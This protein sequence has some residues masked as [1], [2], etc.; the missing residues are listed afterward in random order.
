MSAL[1]AACALVVPQA[2]PPTFE[3][4]QLSD[5][6]YGEGA[7]FGDLDRDGASDVVSGPWWYAGPEFAERFPLYAAQGFDPLRY[8]DFFFA[9]TRDLDGDR[10]LDVLAVGFPGQEA[11]WLENPGKPRAAAGWERH[12]VFATVSGES[13][14]YVD[15]TGDATPEL[16]FLHEGKI[17]Y[18]AP[19]ARDPRAP[20]TFTAVTDAVQEG[21][22][23]HGLG[24][25]DVDGDGQPDVLWRG[26]WFRQTAST[27][28]ERRDFDFASG[29]HGGAQML[30]TDLDGD[31]DGDVV[32][33]LNA[34]GVG[35]SWFEQRKPGEFR[36][37]RVM[38]A[39][40]KDSP[41]GFCV[42]EL[43]ALALGDVD[44]DGVDDVVT[45][46]RFWAHGPE[47][48]PGAG[49]PADLLWFRTVRR[50]S[51]GGVVVELV[52]H[53]IDCDSGVGTQVTAGDVDGDG[54]A[55][56][57]VG[58]K[59]GSFVFLNREGGR[60][61]AAP[62]GRTLN[63]GFEDGS[64]ADWRA[65]GD[66][67]LDQP[68]RGDAPVARDREPA[69]I[70][71]DFFVGGYEHR[72]DD[73]TGRLVSA[74]FRINAPYLSFLVGGGN[75]RGTRVEL[76]RVGDAEPFFKT[77]GANSETMARVV[78]DVRDRKTEL[79]EVRLVDEV[80][81]G[82]GHLNFDDLRLHDARPSFPDDPRVPKILPPD[83]IRHAG[84]S[85]TAAMHAMTVPPGFRVSLVAAEPDLVQPIAFTIDPKGRIWVVEA[86]SYPAKRPAQEGG[87][88]DTILVLED[89]DGNG[90]FET[91]TVFADDLN[92]VSGIEVGFGGVF[93][94]QAPEMLFLPDRDDDLV[95]DGPP[96]VLL[97]GF[98]YQDTHETLNSFT[99]GPDG[100]LYGCHGVFTHSRV[101]KPGTPDAG[102]VPI[103]A[104][105]WRYHPQL[106]N[107]EVFAEGTSNP[108]GID[109]DAHGE[110]F[111][112]ACV[113]PHLYH[114]VQGGRYQRQAGNPFNPYT[115]DDI[116]TIADHLHYLGSTPHGG[117]GRSSAAGGG[118][119]HCGAM[120]YQGG[121]FPPEWRG[122]IFMSN[123]HGNRINTDVLEPNGSGY[124]GRHGEDFLL[125]NDAW[126]RAVAMKTGP[127]GAMYVIDW[128]DEQACHLTDPVR[129]DR[130]NGRMYRISYGAP[131]AFAV[132]LTA[133]TDAQL[134]RMQ[135]HENEWFAR[136]ARVL[137][138]ERDVD[139]DAVAVLRGIFTGHDETPLRLRALWTLFAVGSLDSE[140]LARASR[141]SDE[142]VRAW[143]VRLAT[144]LD[145][146]ELLHAATDDVVRMRE[147]SP[148]V[149][150]ALASAVLSS[151]GFGMNGLATALA[152]LD[153][154]GD[155]PI[156][157][158]LIW[159]GIE[160]LVAESRE[161]ARG[162]MRGS[163]DDRLT[164]W[165]AR[166]AAASPETLDAVVQE[167]E[168][169]A[170]PARRLL[171]LEE[172][173][174]ALKGRRDVA[175]PESWPATY[176]E[177]A[178]G[179]PPALKARL[180]ALAVAFGDV[181]GF[182]VLR[183]T[184]A[185]AAA[186]ADER[187]RALDAL[188]RGR[189]PAVV[190]LLQDLLADTALRG[191]ALRALAS[192]DDARTP[193][194]VLALY[195]AFDADEERDARNT[196]A[197]RPAWARALLEAVRDGGVPRADLG[198]FVI[199]Q[200]GQHGDATLDALVAEAWGAVRATPADKLARVAELKAALTP[201]ALAGANLPRGRALFARTCM[202]CHTLF[203]RGGPGD[204]VGP[205]LTGS[206]RADLDYLLHNL[207]D[208]SAEV[209]RDYQATVAWLTD[210]RIVTGL[211]R[212]E[213]DSALVLRTEN[214]T[215][216]VAKSELDERR[217]SDLSTMPDGL[218]D[219]FTPA[220]VADLVAYLGSPVQVPRLLLPGDERELFDGQTLSGWRGA[221]GL[222]SVADGA[223]VGR[224][225]NGLARNEFLVS[226]ALLRDFKLTLEVKLADDATNSGIQFRS[227]AL[228]DGEVRGYQADVGAG[229]WGKLYEEHGRGILVDVGAADAVRPGDW[230]RYEITAIGA[231]VTLRLNGVLCCDLVDEDGARAG[232]LALQIHGGGPT[233]VRFKN[234]H[235]DLD[236]TNR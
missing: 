77:S 61:P 124:V 101:G 50:P 220:D 150:R 162:G 15:V 62:D 157:P 42:T 18:A 98:G 193:A 147:R 168:R 100:W 183:A 133:M 12:L 225:P 66:A 161:N 26:G 35:L 25:G 230:N 72:G 112:T 187:A 143:A 144:E 202:Q 55:D 47:G 58:N 54:R 194:R 148:V 170:E 195:G 117:N 192:F 79:V 94:G 108:W 38:G 113:I 201:D 114:V 48:S 109:F 229:W 46:K 45:G 10:D 172:I 156:L 70:A 188:V 145:A 80:Q 146:E 136:R 85:P 9:W 189:D 89:K 176:E 60:L 14:W 164:R 217:P 199:R 219:A 64:L 56:V 138:Q 163:H 121:V 33:A 232:V 141:D 96:E 34:H 166:R 51:P 173:E 86:F 88:R 236:P 36:E 129:W 83:P 76:A 6:F 29:G 160:P 3:R 214:E 90:S 30:V 132:D 181:A 198:A 137:L 155:D 105:V 175:M 7:A 13:P 2:I 131:R 135:L 180:D 102:R 149:L 234:L 118:H 71:G 11:F 196:L 69:R 159:Y 167:L 169:G 152:M 68:I 151:D 8:S 140:L 59:K 21:P 215:V 120:I 174:N 128:A 178:A 20:W 127:D 206:N 41:R 222:W 179:A 134:A 228:A 209:G 191:A 28:W 186:P 5:V 23:V 106:A 32:T 97:D 190:P 221:E 82:W 63:L 91:R 204:A 116:K 218:L 57:V 216:V 130:S 154:L 171:L 84:L 87:G 65:E 107:F 40:P 226:D 233:D 142:H 93:V 122:R 104:G 235:L 75:H 103:N 43:H 53:S 110:A 231:R 211:L 153:D 67:F 111:I 115:Y 205:D 95:P 4:R 37:H 125:A 19:N 81:G 177:L 208:P 16:V 139:D 119:A 223:I 78:V 92:L 49:D 203:E 182:P 27:P 185:D 1:L 200:I 184:L 227:V 74:P 165:I 123:I 44:G 24:V 39:E 52:P 99:W 31:G 212:E 158:Y 224:A 73:A 207:I 210:G 213:T 197:S 22:F 17:G 126:F